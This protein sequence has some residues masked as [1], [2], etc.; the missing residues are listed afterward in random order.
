[1]T[2]DRI[3]HIVAGTLIFGS[4][5]LTEFHNDYWVWLTLLVSA[6]LLQYG[7]TK[8]YWL[9]SVLRKMGVPDQAVAVGVVRVAR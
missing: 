4:L 7:I 3:I 6:N 1:M 9:A 5:L 8:W 2:V